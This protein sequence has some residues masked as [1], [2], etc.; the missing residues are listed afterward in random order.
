MAYDIGTARGVIELDYNGR[1]IDDAKKDVDGLK[2][3]GMTAGQAFD[4]TARTTAIAGAA[5]A[6]GLAAGVNAAANFEQRLS[7]I[8]AVS[9][10]TG[11]EMDSLREKALQL[12]AET[13]FSAGE[14]AQAME[15]LVKAGLSVEDVL[16]GAADATVNLAAAGEV[17][18]VTAATIASNAMNQFGIQAEDMVGVVDSIAGAANSSAIDVNE[19]GQSLSQVG[20]VANLAGLTFED[21]AVAIA[22]MGNAG[23][24]GSDAG[25]SLKTM[26]NNLQPTTK[27]QIELFKEL[28]IVTADGSNRFYDAQGNVKD[29][30]GIAGV[31]QNSLKG[32]T[33]QQKQMALETMFGSDAIR[34][35]AVISREGAAGVREMNEEMGKVSAADVAKTRMDN[36]KGSL[37][38][39][40]GSA[41]TAGI[42]VGT[43]LIPVLRDIADALTGAV[44]WFLGLSDAQQKWITIGAATAAAALLIVAA[45]I[46]IVQFIKAFQ[47]ALI[48]IRAVMATTWIAALGPIALVIAAIA[49][50]VAI[51]V[52]LWKKNETFRDAVI[53]VWNAIKAAALAVANWFMSTLVPLFT[54]TWNA[55]V[56]AAKT[57][58]NTLV[59]AIRIYITILMTIIRTGLNIIR[60]VWRTIWA[61]FGP[62]V[63]SIWTIIVSIIRIAWAVI[64]AIVIV[65][66]RAVMT[67]VRAVWNTIRAITSA[68]WNAIKSVIQAVWGV[69]GGTVKSAA[70]RVQ[71]A[72][73]TAWNAVKN[74]TKTVWNAVVGVIRDAVGNMMDVINGIRDKVMGV[75]AGAAGWLFDAGQKIVSGLIN[76]IES[77]FGAL[78]SK[79]AALADKVASVL[80]GS[81]VKEGPLKVLNRGYAGKQIVRMVV[82]GIE[83][84]APQ[85]TMALDAA[86]GAGLDL[87]AP[88]AKP[89]QKP[90][91]AARNQGSR[92]LR[93]VQGR[94][95][96]DPSGRAFIAGVARD[97]DAAEGD[98]ADITD[99]MG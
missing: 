59:M 48:A 36:F 82:D 84:M 31:L 42:A 3:S 80:P 55:I 61:A 14:S 57:I 54:G 66:A 97:E 6:A 63:K 99:R 49:A 24:K 76:G 51:I 45:I 22:L 5:I 2:E 29:M 10:A 9:G 28:G 71:S 68:V 65:G 88:T 72:V 53:A 83:T 47:A 20:A 73:S 33:T 92:G 15:E 27:K 98:F 64:K 17:D 85:L 21:T 40:K 23:I 93:L 43:V 44:N 25:T 50:I 90:V 91:R 4:K 79:A 58:W 37:E 69:I 67:V 18:M 77:M 78:A 52:L 96:L 75:F 81:P 30:A 11:D 70:S 74:I 46:K 56:S 8:E 35:A 34:A 87:P 1:G 7:A 32:L 60:N 39:L 16:N 19:F 89:T 13:A 26:L 94:L 86:T 62:I 41:E 12:G 95:T 38:E